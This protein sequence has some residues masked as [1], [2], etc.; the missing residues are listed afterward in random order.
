MYIALGKRL[1][2]FFVFYAR[3]NLPQRGQSCSLV[4]QSLILIPRHHHPS[5]LI[6]WAGFCFVPVRC[7]LLLAAKCGSYFFSIF[8]PVLFVHLFYYCVFFSRDKDGSSD[9]ELSEEHSKHQ[10]LLQF[11]FVDSYLNLTMKTGFMLK[12]LHSRPDCLESTKFVMKVDDDAFVNPKVS[13][14]NGY[15]DHASVTLKSLKVNHDAFASLSV[16]IVLDLWVN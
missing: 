12:W 11:D 5:Y 16:D 10:D 3:L 8:V 4:K 13:E 9:T 14:K 2:F 1:F 15:A 7:L 6:A